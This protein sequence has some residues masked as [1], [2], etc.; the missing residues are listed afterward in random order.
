MYMNEQNNILIQTLENS[1]SIPPSKKRRNK[2]TLIKLKS[3]PI[4]AW[5]K[6][7]IK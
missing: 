6:E 4:K 3:V 7:N 2:K 1:N 5:R